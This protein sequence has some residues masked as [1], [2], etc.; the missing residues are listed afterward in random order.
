MRDRLVPRRSSALERDLARLADG[1]LSGPRRELLGRMLARSPEL[2]RRL[3]DQRRALGAVRSSAERERA[4]LALRMRHRALRATRDRHS[5]TPR[6]LGV[7]V[8]GALAALAVM[9]GVAATGQA[10]PTV[11]L[12]ATLATRPVV[13]HVAEPPDDSVRLPGLHAAGAGGLPFPYWEDRF[14]WRATGARIDRLD[15]RAMTTVFYRRGAE[16][17]AYTIV[18]G[19]PL[20]LGAGTTRLTRARTELATFET[21]GGQRVVTWLRRGHTCVL[22]GRGVPLRALVELA[23][24]RAHGQIPY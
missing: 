1:T 24:W 17:V 15:G 22:S 14:G 4:P 8:A 9:V 23:S 18:A 10:G 16:R 3:D 2:Q 12:A 11:A 5:A 7:A 20:A 13:A 19:K 21:G 6:W